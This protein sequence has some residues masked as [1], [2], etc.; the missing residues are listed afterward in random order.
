M[1][2]QVQLREAAALQ[3]TLRELDEKHAM[4]EAKL[5]GLHERQK[6]QEYTKMR[7]GRDGGEAR[8]LKFGFLRSQAGGWAGEFERIT[9][10]TGV[11][12]GT[13]AAAEAEA[14]AEGEAGGERATPASAGPA[15]EGDAVEKVVAIYSE[16]EARN[17]SLFKFV[18]EDVTRQK[19]GLMADIAQLQAEEGRLLETVRLVQAQAAAASAP[20]SPAPKGGEEEGEEGGSPSPPSSPAER[21]ALQ[22]SAWHASLEASLAI[23]D[24][25]GREMGLRLPEHMQGKGCSLTTYP[26]FLSLLEQQMHDT[27]DS[28]LR[29]ATHP[30]PPQPAEEGAPAEPRPTLELLKSWTQPRL[31]FKGEAVLLKPRDEP[32]VDLDA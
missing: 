25:L 22:A 4:L 15:L 32:V 10:I 3:V 14:E 8:A 13:E 28:A 12:F 5:E 2:R 16:K 31:L 1:Q 7:S 23:F 24:G 21:L 20:S 26:E 30:A 11:S 27:F 9:Q 17:A 18:T 19:E 29:L 6:Q